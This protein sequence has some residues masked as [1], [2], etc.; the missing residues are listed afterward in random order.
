MPCLGSLL[1]PNPISRAN[2]IKNGYV[3]TK[4]KHSIPAVKH[5]E[6]QTER[7]DKQR[8]TRRLIETGRV[9]LTQGP[10]LLSIFIA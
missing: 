1:R 9:A 4:K 8:C 5:K 7:G 3:S 6:T 2:N 10:T